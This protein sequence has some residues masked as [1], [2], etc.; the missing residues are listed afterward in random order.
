MFLFRLIKRSFLYQILF[1]IAYYHWQLIQTQPLSIIQK[2]KDFITHFNFTHPALEQA[3][4]HSEIFNNAF[5]GVITVC[6]AF[7]IIGSSFFAFVAALALTI[8]TLIHYNPLSPSKAN[9]IIIGRFALNHDFI[10]RAAI[11][12]AIFA[13]AF[14]PGVKRVVD[15]AMI[16]TAHKVDDFQRSREP[17]QTSKKNKKHI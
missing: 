10:L 13:H 9:D 11:I 7:A 2:V 1:V 14:K 16:N 17:K 4:K 8:D 15:D 3:F 12:F 6:G 5:I